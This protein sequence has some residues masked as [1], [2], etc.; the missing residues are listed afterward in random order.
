L[1]LICP[2]CQ[3]AN[4][5]GDR[6]CGTCGTPLDPTIARAQGT[7]QALR[8]D[9]SAEVAAGRLQEER[10]W[11]TV[12]FADLS[13]FTSMAERMDPEDVKA[14]VSRC[15]DRISQVVHEFG[16]RVT[17]LAG[18]SVMA[19]WGAPVAHEDDAERAVRAAV[20]MPAALATLGQGE[21]LRLHVGVNTGEVV[22]G[23]LGPEE[24]RDFTAIG[25]TANTAARLMAAAP[26]GS[27]YVGEQTY[28][29]TRSCVTYRSVA[30]VVAKGKRHPLAAWQVVT[31]SPV[32]LARP[33][34]SA[35]MTGRQGELQLVQQLWSKVVGEARPHLVSIVG[36]PGIGKSRLLAEVVSG[37]LGEATVL[38]GRCIPYGGAGYWAMAV[39]LKEVAGISGA[40]PPA[41][42]GTKLDALVT[43]VAGAQLLPEETALIAVHL[44]RI[45]GIEA[46]GLASS[47]DGQSIQ[48]SV[49]RFFEA[50]ARQ[51][52]CCLCLED[53]H[54]AEETLLELV[55]SVAAWAQDVPLLILTTA[56][57]ELL[58]RRPGWGGGVRCFASLA[59]EPLSIQDTRRLT[60]WLCRQRRLPPAATA[61]IAPR[62]GGNPLFA[63]ELVAMVAER[64][65]GIRPGP[66]STIKALISA[67]IDLLPSA[68]RTTLQLA[69]VL[70]TVVWPAAVQALGAPRPVE[71]LLASLVRKGHLSEVPSSLLE[72]QRQYAF[73]HH[74][75]QEVAYETLPKVR[76]RELHALAADW[77][78]RAAGDRVEEYLE[79]LA[80]HSEQAGREEQAL[81]YLMRTAD[82]AERSAAPQEQA[83]LLERAIRI[84]DA[85]GRGELVRGLRARRGRALC[86]FGAWAEAREEFQAALAA[87]PAQA[88]AERSAL[89]VELA[90]VWRWLG[91]LPALR[92]DASEARALARRLGRDDLVAAAMAV[93]AV[94]ESSQGHLQASLALYGRAFALARESRLPVLVQGLEQ[95]QMIL[96]WLG[97]SSEAV[98]AGG[99][100]VR[101]AQAAGDTTTVVRALSALGLA[102]GGSGRYPEAIRTFEEARRFAEQHGLGMWLARTLAMVGGLHLEVSDFDGAER[103]AEEARE[104]GR[105]DGFEASLASSGIDLLLNYA[106]R[107]EPDRARALIGEVDGMVRSASG[108]HGWLWRMRFAQALAEL[109]AARGQWGEA[110]GYASAAIRQARARGR[111]KY[112]VLGL[113]TRALALAAKGRRQTALAAARM[114]A[115]KAEAGGD[116]VLEVRAF[117]TLAEL[118]GEDRALLAARAAAR[119]I[120][121]VLPSDLR[122]YFDTAP[123]VR[124]L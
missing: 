22:S 65:G 81:D 98:G 6:Y 116:P 47:A 102:Y 88:A 17:A 100:A 111:V 101:A 67:R 31:V 5:A 19:M 105:A 9:A 37:T 45:A 99:E 33:L 32:P 79:L 27:I 15:A 36:E 92:R 76:R 109:H 41:E 120:A 1:A 10:R 72:G 73:K 40:D 35:P 29:A 18:D 51:R 106:R 96:Y 87:L 86:N 103:L 3:A 20:A 77:I 48:T 107:G 63:E 93:L 114:A 75:A 83:S 14:L 85:L 91:D 49:R 108:V 124:A 23:F 25:D 59:L 57:P 60:D 119:R 7:A 118:S 70:G 113:V 34:G 68:E 30:P 66:G 69:S 53:V 80:Y 8:G 55:E 11:V 112:E 56:R 74:L 71:D 84:G 122:A 43:Q 42:A 58:D 2:S 39:A 95:R 121:E 26:A 97:R 115:G 61:E 64:G 4:E 52:P 82:R 104:A 62:T 16:G 44:R 50:L 94:G 12:V 38:S 46:T 21:T 110:V 117:A 78:Q 90:T 89:L 28:Q 13:G 54:W 123:Q 24:L